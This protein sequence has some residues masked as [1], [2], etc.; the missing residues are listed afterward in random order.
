MGMGDIYLTANQPGIGGRLKVQPED[1]FVEEIPLYLPS[2]AGHHVYIEIEKIGLSTYAAIKA[3]AQALKISPNDIGYA[4]L[5]DARAVTR[6]T[7][8]VS[9]ITPEAALNL[10]LPNIKILGAKRHSNKLR[11]GHLAG[12]RFVIRVREVTAAAL[13][14]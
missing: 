11:V 1:F 3:I 10:N 5:K 12:N 6:Q 14:Q 4:G 2:G 8:S 7:L 9:G 13:P